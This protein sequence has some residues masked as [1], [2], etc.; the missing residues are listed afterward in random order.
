[1][2][3]WRSV[4]RCCSNF[5]L[6]WSGKRGKKDRVLNIIC[7]ASNEYLLRVETAQHSRGLD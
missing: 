2:D 6:L 5:D 4:S 7:H 3:G 1:M